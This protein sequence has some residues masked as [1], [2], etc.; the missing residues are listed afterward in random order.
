MT[1]A[2]L[3]TAEARRRLAEFGPNEPAPPRRG[4]ALGELLTFLAN[5]LVVILLIASG[6]AFVVGEELNAL[7]IALM[8]AL[9]VALNFIQTFRSRKA[10]EALRAQVAPTARVVRDGIETT[11]PRRDIVPGDVVMLAA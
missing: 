7:I 11:V 3:T 10:A 8:V 6:V 1:P 4:A 5:P 2:G 9:S